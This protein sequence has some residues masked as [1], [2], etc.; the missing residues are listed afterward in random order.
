MHLGWSC[1]TWVEYG[2]QQV[3]LTEEEQVGAAI[4]QGLPGRTISLQEVSFHSLQ[5][6][7]FNLQT[8]ARAFRE[9]P[10]QVPGAPLM[11]RN[12]FYP[13]EKS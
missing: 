5:D 2:S 8:K 11:L 13:R 9:E 3:T 12:P 1:E 4:L 6:Q 10:Q 7:G